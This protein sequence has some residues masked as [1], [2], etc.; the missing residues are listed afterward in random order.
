[1]FLRV[2]GYRLGRDPMLIH[3]EMMGMFGAGTF[4]FSHLE[5]WLRGFVEI[6]D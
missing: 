3:A 2:N 1:V 6:A 5:G 4:G